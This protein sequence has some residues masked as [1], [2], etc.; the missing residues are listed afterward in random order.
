MAQATSTPARDILEK[1][2]YVFENVLTNEEIDRLRQASREFFKSHGRA[3][4]GGGSKQANAA[5]EVPAIEWLFYHPRILQCFREALDTNTIMFTSH[6]D[7]QK[8]RLG[9]WHKD[10]GTNPAQ[11]DNLGYF[12]RFAY[13]ADDCRVYKMGIY[14]QDH[15]HDNA[16]LW[17]REGSHRMKS[18]DDGR[19][20]YTA[21]KAGSVIV[22]DVRISHTGHLPSRMQA[23]LRNMSRSLPGGAVI[24]FAVRKTRLTYRRA[25]GR[26]RMA[27]FFTFGIPND[28]TLEFSRNNMLRQIRLT[29]GTDPKL[30]ASLRQALEREN[31]LLAED[32][33]AELCPSN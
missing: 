1:G 12:S 6:A 11:P 24:D 3:E 2:Y 8:D 30:P 9:G 29:P 14:L 13:D 25:I 5:V 22:F 23:K 20:V 28:Y 19:L 27:I 33:L 18:V 31:V 4:L 10:D 21:T 16:G 17:V 15:D 32:Q 7:V 26:E